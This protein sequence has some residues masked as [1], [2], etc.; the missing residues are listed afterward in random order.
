[1]ITVADAFNSPV[2]VT[3]A[4]FAAVHATDCGKV[5]CCPRA[6]PAAARSATMATAQT[7]KRDTLMAL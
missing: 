5:H 7:R 3:S 6:T 4:A 1:M 2:S